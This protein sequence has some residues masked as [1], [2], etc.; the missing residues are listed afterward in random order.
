M[1]TFFK[2]GIFLREF[3][4]NE[5]V[6]YSLFVPSKT[7]SKTNL[8]LSTP[9]LSSMLASSI[10]LLRHT[11]SKKRKIPPSLQLPYRGNIFLKG[12]KRRKSKVP[13]I[14]TPH[15]LSKIRYEIMI[16]FIKSKAPIRFVSYLY[17]IVCLLQYI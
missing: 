9:F 3:Y 4:K 1:L 2:M 11:S 13:R 14:S 12:E 17:S 10:S 8:G 6:P 16:L 5:N 15:H 7:N